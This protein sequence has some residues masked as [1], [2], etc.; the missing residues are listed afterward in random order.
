VTFTPLLAVSWFYSK[1]H[2]P[3]GRALYPEDAKSSSNASGKVFTM[4]NDGGADALPDGN[5]F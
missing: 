5:P 1:T 3:D 4:W 2:A